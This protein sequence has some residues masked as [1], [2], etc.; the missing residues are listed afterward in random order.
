MSLYDWLGG[1]ASSEEMNFLSTEN[2]SYQS[3][4]AHMSGA[5]LY[6]GIVSEKHTGAAAAGG[7][8]PGT[9]P[10]LPQASRRYLSVRQKSLFSRGKTAQRRNITLKVARLNTT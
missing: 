8:P 4:R 3:E 10:F 1:V 9:P 5:A 2:S 7:I 6:S